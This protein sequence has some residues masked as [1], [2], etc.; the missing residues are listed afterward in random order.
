MF[1]YHNVILTDIIDCADGTPTPL[2]KKLVELLKGHFSTKPD[3]RCIVSVRTRV[4]AMLL[5]QYLN[6]DP[7]L[8]SFKWNATYLTG[9]GPGREEGG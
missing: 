7:S 6:N 1:F 9:S 8:Q 4:L 3:S 5:A 2:L